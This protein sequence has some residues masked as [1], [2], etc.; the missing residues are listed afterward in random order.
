MRL[1]P[2]FSFIEKELYKNPEVIGTAPYIETQ[3]LISSGSFLKG[4]YLYGIDPEYEETV[5]SISNHIIDGS[6]SSLKDDE[7]YFISGKEEIKPLI[8]K[9]QELELYTKDITEGG[10]TYT[11]V[12]KRTIGTLTGTDS[13]E[14]VIHGF[15]LDLRNPS[16]WSDF[17]AY[18]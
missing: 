5:S 9:R 15:D 2:E 6:L 3:G 18:D 4:V 12:I 16:S 8:L 1:A 10:Q 11:D 17:T 14:E 13:G 7:N